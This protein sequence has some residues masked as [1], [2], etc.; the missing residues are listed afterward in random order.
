MKVVLAEKPSVAR[1]IA[2]VIGAK[3]RKDGYI[4]GN[5]YQVTWAIGHLVQLAYF[6]AY[7][8]EWKKW[9]INNLPLIPD[10]LKKQLPKD[11]GLRRQ[12]K[13]IKT[14]FTS[15]STT[16]IICA[17]DAGREGEL[18]FRYIYDYA[19]S[20][21]PIKRLWISSMTNQAIL[22]GFANLE[23]GDKYQNLFDS[24]VSRSEADWLVGLNATRA[25]TCQF[26]RGS[27]TF[28]VGRVQTPVLKMIVDRFKEN[29]NFISKPFYQ[30]IAEIQ[31]KN[32]PYKGTLIINDKTKFTAKDQANEILLSVKPHKQG[33][34]TELE[35][36]ARR[37]KPP[38]LFD[39]TT[40]QKEA[41]KRF[42]FS[43]TKTLELVQTLYQNHKLVTYP[44]TSSRYISDD[45]VAT[46]PGIIA[47][48]AQ[49]PEF[50]SITAN[51]TSTTPGKR[52]V[53]N[54]KIEDHHAIIPTDTRLSEPIVNKLDPDEKKI[55]FLILKQF[56]G[57]F[58]SDCVKENTQIISTFGDHN[59][60]TKGTTIKEKGWRI[61]HGTEQLTDD[62]DDKDDK[63][64][65]QSNLP[66]IDK[67]DPVNQ[68]N[69]SLKEGKTKPKPLHTEASLLSMMETAGKQIDDESLKEAL[70][71]CG[72]GTPAT[73]AAILETLIK[74]HYIA[75]Q[76]NTLI[77]CEKGLVLIDIVQD[78]AFLSPEMT[79]KWEEKLNKIAKGSF[80]RD[81]FM[82]EIKNFTK[83]AITNVKSSTIKAESLTSNQN[84]K[85]VIGECPLCQGEVVENK[86][87]FG[88]S[89]WKSKDCRFT[90]W[91]NIGGKN[92]TVTVAKTLITK[93]K[94]AKLK[95]FK[96][97][98]T[99]NAY[100]AS[101][102]L[103]PSGE[104]KLSFD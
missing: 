31:H 76:K 51:I 38:Q 91:K 43:A 67:N 50:A 44:R 80:S 37:E 104:V 5:G 66:V 86:K 84:T 1:D 36:K 59:F 23:P 83:S 9:D 16:E 7:G 27:G 8:D 55:Y 73:R 93:K 21:K 26:S 78:E 32:G 71:E 97:K 41:N 101:L 18:I 28:S 17:T 103:N 29:K 6:E 61:V 68:T 64:E 95:G 40:I 45:M 77:P 81:Q 35:K 48:I 60:I 11:A 46:L 12:F 20:K 99:G 58:L 42:K 24:A 69:T 75:R 10:N 65:I 72:L 33:N 47:N 15:P 3:S 53:D 85:P 63:E 19:K 4:E 34:V 25:Y 92:I 74:R 89:N 52:F 87:S 30:I 100:E 102:V 39:L 54:N 79:G 14:L 82:A 56:L 49:L 2:A 90:I 88:C 96:S 62:P 22:D 13:A 57:I 98:K 70:K 94:T